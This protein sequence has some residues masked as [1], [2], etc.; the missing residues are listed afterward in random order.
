M[1]AVSAARGWVRRH[2][3]LT[4]LVAI[5]VYVLLAAGLGNVLSDLVSDDHEAAQ[6]ALGHLIPLPIGIVLLL[7]AVR[8]AGN[9]RAVW[10]ERPT[11][12]MTP[13]RWYLLV[14]PVLAVG[15]YLVESTQIPWAERG[16]GIIALVAVGTLL[17]GLG[18]ELAIRGVLL[19]AVRERHGEFVTL[20]VTSLVFALIHIPGSIV[21]GNP[22]L[23]IVIQVAG[24]SV[25]GATYYWIRR[26]TGRLWAG[27]LVHAFTDWVLYLSGSDVVPAASMSQGQ[28]PTD[29]IVG[30][31]ELVLWLFLAIG[32]VSVIRED[33]RNREQHATVTP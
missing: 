3:V 30:N 17:V 10:R 1:S 18:E 21:A 24:L 32:V 4:A 5:V 7:L 14:I 19:A 12:T 16:I 22:P 20:L 8:W 15:T 26:V 28:T 31:A 6:F 25:V 27:V 33:R 13:H 11:P 29:L 9:G 23:V 2:G